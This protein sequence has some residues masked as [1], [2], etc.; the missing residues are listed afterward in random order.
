[1][2]PVVTRDVGIERHQDDCRL[3]PLPR[4]AAAGRITMMK[5]TRLLLGLCLV[6]MSVPPAFAQ[7][8]SG[9]P[10]KATVTNAEQELI[11]LSKDK[12]RWMA[13]RN[14]EALDK[15]FADV[16]IFVHMGITLSKSEELDTIKTG[17]IQYKEAQ[18]QEVSVRFLGTTAILLN[19]I[20][21]VAVVGGNEVVNPFNVTEVYV[22][23]DGAW[24]LGSLS[25]T[26]L[27]TP[28]GQ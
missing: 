20:R 24:K 26:R 8:G 7:A 15:L 19:K 11:T 16:A 5:A 27:M 2:T 21:L 9:T 28:P 18:I 13:E 4:R 22:K 3:R 14:V 25:F 1:V 23:V 17:R 12:W 10:A 6:L